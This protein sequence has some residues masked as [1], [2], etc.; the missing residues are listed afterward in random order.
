MTKKGPNGEKQKAKKENV[1]NL[2]NVTEALLNFSRS[3]F[4]ETAGSNLGVDV[5][6]DQPTPPIYSHVFLGVSSFVNKLAECA[7]SMTKL[8]ICGTSTPIRSVLG[9]LT[10]HEVCKSYKHRKA[11]I[12]ITD[13]KTQSYDWCGFLLTKPHVA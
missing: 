1:S 5:V 2:D 8:D 12:H 13:P 3:L 7:N 10:F 11:F 4:C 6:W 9:G